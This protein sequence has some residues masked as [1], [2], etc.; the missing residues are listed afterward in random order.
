MSF[1]FSFGC[2]GFRS[3]QSV[4]GSSTFVQPFRRIPEGERERERKRETEMR[5]PITKLA[6]IDPNRID[7]EFSRLFPDFFGNRS[8]VPVI[9]YIGRITKKSRHHF[10]EEDILI[11]SNVALYLFRNDGR[12]KR[13]VSLHK[14]TEVMVFPDGY[15]VYRVPSEYDMVFRLR[16][17]TESDYL[18]N[19]LCVIQAVTMAKRLPVRACAGTY[20]SFPA[21]NLDRPSSYLP[22]SLPMPMWPN[23][24]SANSAGGSSDGGLLDDLLKPPPPPPPR[25]NED[26]DDDEEG[27]TGSSR[28][29]LS[30][31]A[32]MVL[33]HPLLDPHRVVRPSADG[34]RQDGG[35]EQPSSPTRI[36]KR[37]AAASSPTRPNRVADA[38]P[39]MAA[40]SSGYIDEEIR[41]LD[42]V[43]RELAKR[44]S[45]HLQSLIESR[46]PVAPALPSDTSPQAAGGPITQLWGGGGNR[47]AP[48]LT[49][50]TLPPVSGRF[51]APIA[52]GSRTTTQQPTTGSGR[53]SV[54][55]LRPAS[56]DPQVT[57]L[58][59]QVMALRA[60]LTESNLRAET[61]AAELAIRTRS[62]ATS[63]VA[64]VR[65]TIAA[66]HTATHSRDDRRDERPRPMAP[67]VVAAPTPLPSDPLFAVPTPPVKSSGLSVVVP[68]ASCIEPETP[69]S[70]RL[71]AAVF[72]R[73][74]YDRPL[75]D[76]LALRQYQ[77]DT[78]RQLIGRMFREATY[79]T[80][81]MYRLQEELVQLVKDLETDVA[82]CDAHAALDAEEIKRDVDRPSSLPAAV[83]PSVRLASA[84]TEDAASFKESTKAITVRPRAS[85]TVAMRRPPPETLIPQFEEIASVRELPRAVLAP[86][87]QLTVPQTRG[88]DPVGVPPSPS[89][90]APVASHPA[91]FSLPHAFSNA[92]EQPWTT[93][94]A[95]GGPMMA[96]AARQYWLWYQ[97]YFYPYQ[98]QPPPP[99]P[100]PQTSAPPPTGP[101]LHTARRAIARQHGATTAHEADGADRYPPLRLH[102]PHGWA[103]R[104]TAAAGGVAAATGPLDHHTN[105]QRST[106]P[107]TRR[108]LASR[109]PTA[110]RPQR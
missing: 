55:V 103:Q 34:S 109:S 8:R 99:Q 86:D 83:L 3:K 72:N 78:K 64:G 96:E 25:R 62:A 21:V 11:V 38:P 108:R 91:A 51:A 93:P 32:A 36:G 67:A 74:I 40:T 31:E 73:S 100:F 37:S 77:I 50:G 89:P 94:A 102:A 80:A 107:T 81:D 56:P 49:E 101:G 7:P 10:S 12:L 52:T 5:D 33:N 63:T 110:T 24:D 59:N 20:K 15:N 30:K 42:T 2:L 6:V 104:A 65:P 23:A 45:E 75:T 60:E 66:A 106:T 13:C 16:Q 53:E 29:T 69:A 105:R 43:S 18:I 46:P 87:T 27:A 35:P 54:D 70:G 22:E 26:G 57:Q 9:H 82:E 85:T 92:A 48:P 76:R 61:A 14:L 58:R 17:T 95:A 47:G 88:A 28:T 41:R 19:I 84:P 71:A 97:T 1:D 90:P 39:D 98:Q 79:N 44:Q 4:S 68:H